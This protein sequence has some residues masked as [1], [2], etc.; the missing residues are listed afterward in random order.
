MKSTILA[1]TLLL[2][3]AGASAAQFDITRHECAQMD[4]ARDGIKCSVAWQQNYGNVLR[5]RVVGLSDDPQDKKDRT[6]YA[7]DKT[8]HNWL[9]QGGVWIFMRTTKRDGQQMERICSRIKGKQTEHCKP[10]Y[11]IN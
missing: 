1:L 7:I 9:A 5:I 8:I 10:W 6:K 2:A 4:P 3:A 11:P